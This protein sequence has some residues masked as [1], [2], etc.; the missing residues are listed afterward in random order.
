MDIIAEIGSVHD[1]S[2]GNACKLIELAADCGA[3]IVKFQTHIPEEE[4]LFDA[5]SPSYFNQ[6]S[7]FE[8]FER[9]SFSFKQWENLKLKSQENGLKFMS[10]PF[11]EAAIDLLEKVGVEMYKVPS[12]EVTNHPLLEKLSMIGKPVYLSTGMSNWQ[13]IDSALGILV[14][15]V[16]VILM[17]CTTSYPCS[18]EKVGINVIE[19][20]KEKYPKLKI[21]FSDHTKGISAGPIATFV[22]SEV[23]EKHLTFS[24]D[25]YGSDAYNALPPKEFKLY[26]DLIKEAQIMRDNKVDKNDLKDLTNM[27]KIFEKSIVT[28]KEINRGNLIDMSNIKFKKPGDGISATEY[29]NLIGRK[30]NKDL[31]KDVQIKYEDFL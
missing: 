25:M 3:N 9:T 29:K 24:R 23:I 7:R 30:I 13:E 31:L 20:M 16:Q 10:S 15:S 12:G 2:F 18:Y 1:G 11:S 6:E 27:K 26:V 28:A 22:G 14:N 8:Y 19:E 4:S 17:Q 5:P 21:G